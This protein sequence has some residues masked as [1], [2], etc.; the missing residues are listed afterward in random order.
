MGTHRGDESDK[1]IEAAVVGFF[2]LL[3]IGA[4]VCGVLFL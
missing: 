2:A 4:V 1:W 3:F